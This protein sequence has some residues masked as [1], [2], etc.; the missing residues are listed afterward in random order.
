MTDHSLALFFQSAAFGET[1]RVRREA[2]PGRPQGLMG[3]E[4]AAT[5]FLRALLQ[6]GRL[7]LLEAIL[8]SERDRPSL[9]AACQSTLAGRSRACRVRMTPL[10]ELPRWLRDRHGTS[11]HI[12]KTTPQ[13]EKT[14]PQIEEAAQPGDEPRARVLHFPNPPEPSFAWTRRVYRPHAMAISGVTHTL[15]SSAAMRLIWDWTRAPV[16]PYDR[17][18][19]TSTAVTRMV[20]AVTDVM[21]EGNQGQH[22]FLPIAQLPIG[23]DHLRHHPATPEQ[24]RAARVKLGI[25]DDP[26]HIV[27]LFVGRLSHHAKAHPGPLWE[28]AQHVQTKCPNQTLHVVMSGWFTNDNTRSSFIR[29]AERLAPAVDTHF[30]D[31]LDA[32]WRDHVWDSADLFVSLAD[33][34]Q[35][36]FGL[37]NLEAM[38]RGLPVI[39]TDWNGY[40]DT[41]VDGKTGFRVATAMVRGS[42]PDVTAQLMGGCISYDQFLARVG[43]TVIV[44]TAAAARAI[45][46][47][48]QDTALRRR[49]GQQAHQ[50]VRRH[51]AWDQV[52][53][54][55]ESLWH[56]MDQQRREVEAP[57]T[58]ARITT[59]ITKESASSAAD[60]TTAGVPELYPPI[61]VSFAGYPTHWLDLQTPIRFTSDATQRLRCSLDDPLC[62]HT[63][64]A[65]KSGG[66]IIDFETIRQ[67]ISGSETT[68]GNTASWK[69]TTLGELA[70]RM[71]DG[72][73]DRAGALATAAWLMKYGVV[74]PAPRA[75]DAPTPA[76]PEAG[77]IDC[78]LV[79]TCMGRLDDLQQSLPT[80]IAQPGV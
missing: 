59:S 21:A 78:T 58:Q 24:R 49:L 17:L 32:Y 70:S 22:P 39:A 43:Q 18:I 45:Q 48:V 4:V 33:S 64:G 50:H 31:G 26:R 79:A 52:I 12:E 23:I 68:Q 72:S 34:I 60:S 67:A 69:A 20:R 29:T 54:Q 30:V 46:T 75:G 7:E 80:W 71:A 8:E 27:L 57:T 2:G 19:T 35:E 65:P 25:P 36:T 16:Q 77:V 66:R 53:P 9:L 63:P 10:A 61:E 37:T 13:V 3:R 44:D 74:V 38:S 14:T 51:F 73:G 40:R 41:I 11:P 15:C 42:L 62:Q 5:S 47:L 76:K 55:Y 1:L 56:E 28:A 6:N